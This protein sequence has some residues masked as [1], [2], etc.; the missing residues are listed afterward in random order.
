MKIRRREFLKVIGGAAAAGYPGQ[1]LVRAQGAPKRRFE[2]ETLRVLLTAGS[3][4][5]AMRNNI[6]APFMKETGAQVLVTEAL[7]RKSVV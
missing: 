3:E 4:G 7:D 1:G 2:G 6:V 5:L